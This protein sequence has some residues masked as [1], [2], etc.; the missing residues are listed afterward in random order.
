MCVQ[1]RPFSDSNNKGRAQGADIEGEQFS[2]CVRF[3]V[4]LQVFTGFQCFYLR[5]V[6]RLAP[7]SR[8]VRTLV[9]DLFRAPLLQQFYDYQ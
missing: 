1:N 7:V 6:G 5:R 3:V 9:L 2:V 8:L 4:F